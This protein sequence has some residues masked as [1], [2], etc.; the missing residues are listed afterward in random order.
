VRRWFGIGSVV[1]ILGWG[2]PARADD[3]AAAEAL[4]REARAL[5]AEGKTDAACQK[6]K[7]SQALDASPGTLLNLAACHR[8]QGKTAT[9]WAEFIAAGRL[10]R[11]QRKDR[12]EAEATRRAAELESTLNY[13][14]VRVLDPVPGLEVRREGALLEPSVYGARVPVDPGSYSIAASAPGYQPRHMQVVISSRK[15]ELLE[16]PALQPENASASAA[17][18]SALPLAPARVPPPAQPTPLGDRQAAH[19]RTVPY[20]VGSLGGAFLVT[21]AVAGVLALR[22]NH[23]ASTLCPEP[24]NCNDA[25]ARS[26]ADRRDTEALVA[27]IGVAAGLVGL[28]VAVYLLLSDHSGAPASAQAL[29]PSV[30][31]NRAGLTFVGHF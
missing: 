18:S 22:S 27:N 20:V 25:S 19:S 30:E 6:F 29:V 1:A 26:T 9:A 2:G 17:P 15:D 21:G 28:G 14:T 11:A 5:F 12:Q 7:A 3:P 13:L 4:F 8:A 24:S 16:I 10:A 23:S 31:P